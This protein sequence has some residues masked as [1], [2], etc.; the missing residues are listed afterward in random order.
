ML[1]RSVAVYLDGLDK[2]DV[3]PFP[4]PHAQNFYGRLE[5]PR[6]SIATQ[7]LRAGLAKLQEWS[8]KFLPA[9]I[10]DYRA[11]ELAAKSARLRLWEDWV[12]VSRGSEG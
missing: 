10:E 4:P 2:I 11:A 5:H 12:A 1:N 9:G 8:L 7:L 3:S 6:G